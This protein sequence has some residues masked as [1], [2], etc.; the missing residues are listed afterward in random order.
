MLVFCVFSLTVQK[1]RKDSLQQLSP[2]NISINHLLVGFRWQLYI[3]CWTT[4]YSSGS[5]SCLLSKEKSFLILSDSLSSLQA[6][7][8][9]KYDHPVLVKI[10]ELYMELTR[11]GREIVFIWALPMWALEEIQL[12]TL[13]LRTPLIMTSQMSP[14]PSHTWSLG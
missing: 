1:Q 10:L 5:Q 4:N 9:I 12:Q 14:S 8:N 13:L 2:L 3:Y 11:D 6:I 7:Y